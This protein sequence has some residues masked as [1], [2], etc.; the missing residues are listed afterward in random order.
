MGN[1]IVQHWCGD[2]PQWA[3]QAE[4]TIRKYARTIN[5]EYLLLKDYPMQEMV[6]Q[7]Q[8]KPWL[9]LQKL[10][11]LNKEFDSYDNVLLLDMD[12]IATKNI[13]NIFD[14]EGIGRL[15][16]KGMSDVNASKNGR[17]WSTLYHKN[18]SMFFGNCVK[19]KKEYRKELRKALK[20]D[21][22][23]NN[24]SADGLPPNDEILMHHL[25]YVTG[26]LK[27]HKELQLPHDRFCDLPE[28]AH[29]DAT[30]LHFCNARKNNIPEVVRNLYGLEIL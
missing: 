26:I 18:E 30:L 21:I 28:E 22:I 6:N 10:Y 16:L 23:D 24:K 17:K 19:L 2:F 11:V 1:I 25:F 3:L 4:Q 8:E 7:K 20:K 29:K 27:D 5:S 14:Y 9:V 15:H 13:D 12:M